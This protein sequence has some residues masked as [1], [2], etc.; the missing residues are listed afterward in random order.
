MYGA[1]G[2]GITLCRRIN[3]RTWLKNFTLAAWEAQGIFNVW[4]TEWNWQRFCACKFTVT[5]LIMISGNKKL[6]EFICWYYN[7]MKV[8]IVSHSYLHCKCNQQRDLKMT[9]II[10][11]C[12]HLN[13][14]FLLCIQS[15]LPHKKDGPLLESIYFKDI[16]PKSMICLLYSQADRIRS[17]CLR[18]E[19]TYSDM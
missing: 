6:K 10:V 16:C 3:W 7:Y 4:E 2:L 13:L 1:I 12:G 11:P 14:E 15:P 8:A 18:W 5:P 17:H 19:I 9:R